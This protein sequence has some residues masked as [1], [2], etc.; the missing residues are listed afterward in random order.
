MKEKECQNYFESYVKYLIG[1]KVDQTRLSL[2]K[3]HIQSCKDCQD[4]FIM[5]IDIIDEHLLES[6]YEPALT[7]NDVKT[8]IKNLYTT[9]FDNTIGNIIKYLLIY[10]KCRYNVI[11][12]LPFDS[13]EELYE[14]YVNRLIPAFDEQNSMYA[15]NLYIC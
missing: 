12:I 1:E 10:K 7:F 13:T 4:N 11:D 14:F 3:N 15:E 6:T 9:F 5:F 2:I 8:I